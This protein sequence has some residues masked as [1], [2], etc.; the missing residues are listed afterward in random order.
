VSY[1]YNPTGQ[2]SAVSGYVDAMSW[3][4]SG[5]LATMTYANGATTTYTYDNNRLWL[6]TTDVKKGTTTL[7]TAAY[8]Y[9]SNGMVQTMTQGT[10][11]PSRRPTPMMIWTGC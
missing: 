7:Y 11:D 9:Y 10:P 6:T 5:Q 2:F 3:I 1:T 8:S 4:P